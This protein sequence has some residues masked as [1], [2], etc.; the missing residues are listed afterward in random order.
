MKALQFSILLLAILSSIGC[1]GRDVRIVYASI[2]RVP[3]SV[4]GLPRIATNTKVPVTVGDHHSEIDA[5]GYYILSAQD[6]ETMVNALQNE[7]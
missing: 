2:A 5:G 3:D 4:S 7:P 1:L 6:L